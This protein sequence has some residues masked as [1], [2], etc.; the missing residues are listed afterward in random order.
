MKV[1]IP[2]GKPLILELIDG[3]GKTLFTMQEEHQLSPGEYITPGQPRA[4]F[5]GICGAESGNIPVSAAAP[6]MLFS[7]IEVQRKDQGHDR[8]PLLPPPQL[9]AQ[10]QTSR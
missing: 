4:V 3:S 2:A 10:T 7:E 9:T 1:A 6:A 5:N 8:P